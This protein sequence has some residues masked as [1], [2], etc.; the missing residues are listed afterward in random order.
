MPLF[1]CTKTD[2][3]LC[4]TGTLRCALRLC[5][6]A[7]KCNIVHP[8][9]VYAKRKLGVL[10]DKTQTVDLAIAKR[11][12][13]WQFPA[14]NAGLVYLNQNNT[15]PAS[16][17]VRNTQCVFLWLMHTGFRLLYTGFRAAKHSSKPRASALC[18]VCC[19]ETINT[20]LSRRQQTE[21]F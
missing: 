6:L 7:K 2:S 14:V 16:F 21:H 8:L 5:I 15:V 18:A 19:N 10:P 3:L 20:S 11:S 12:L 9:Q 4:Y 13:L 1:V 17:N